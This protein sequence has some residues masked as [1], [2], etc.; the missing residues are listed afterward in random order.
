MSAIAFCDGGILKQAREEPNLIRS[1]CIEDSMKKLM[2]FLLCSAPLM[3]MQPNQEQLEQARYMNYARK[4]M[5]ATALANATIMTVSKGGCLLL[6]PVA[7]V[8]IAGVVGAK[9]IYDRS[10]GN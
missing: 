8:G 9:Y 5:I 6:G 2:L 3:A 1:E 10:K 7:T 4:G